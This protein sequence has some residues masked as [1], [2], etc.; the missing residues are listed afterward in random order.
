MLAGAAVTPIEF[1]GGDFDARNNYT[2]PAQRVTITDQPTSLLRA[3]SLRSLG[4]AQNTFANESFIDEL[5]HAAGADPID[6]R[7]KHISDA[8]MRAVLEGLRTYYQK[9]RGVAFTWFEN[10]HAIVGAVADVS[11]DRSKGVA[12]VNHVW[13]A[14]D[15]GLIVNPDGLRNQIEGNAIQASSRAMLEQVTFDRN[16]VTSVDWD[17][18]PIFRF[19]AVPDVTISLI[20]RRDQPILGAG[21]ATTSLMAPAIANAIFAQTGKRLRTVPFAPQLVHAT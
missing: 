1:L 3:S 16:H 17:T 4:A 14:H 8:R 2:I 12:R 13:V 18:Y 10:S 19:D 5:A 9:G 15:C 21:E 11:V 6:F 7:L 20:D